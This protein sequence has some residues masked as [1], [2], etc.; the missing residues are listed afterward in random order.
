MG[1]G[2]TI[3]TIP[4]KSFGRHTNS[5]ADDLL[6]RIDEMEFNS[7]TGQVFA[8]QN[9]GKQI[10]LVDI[11]KR[12]AKELLSDFIGKVSSMAFGEFSMQFQLILLG[13]SQ[14]DCSFRLSRQQSVL[15]RQD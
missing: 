6:D 14:L 2:K 7:L 8:T 5:F 12:K 13:I 4:Q 15:G 1:I 9:D 10:V 3:V 11:E